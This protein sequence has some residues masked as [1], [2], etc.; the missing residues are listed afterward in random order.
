MKLDIELIKSLLERIEKVTPNDVFESENDVECYHLKQMIDGKLIEGW[1]QPDGIGDGWAAEISD[2]T[3][4]GHEF[5]AATRQ[6]KI[7]ERIKDTVLE[8][9]VA[10]TVSNVLFIA[11]NLME[12]IL[13]D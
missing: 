1:S 11:K 2:L 6:H 3:L 7:W 13:S 5:L 8:K 12:Q 4:K 10:F 9:G